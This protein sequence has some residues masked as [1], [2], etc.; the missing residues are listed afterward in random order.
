MIEKTV[1]PKAY[2]RHKDSAANTPEKLELNGIAARLAALHFPLALRV[3]ALLSE[4]L[5][6]S[7]L[8]RCLFDFWPVSGR[9]VTNHDGLLELSRFES[10]CVLQIQK[11]NDSAP[12]TGNSLESYWRKLD[13]M[14]E[15]DKENSKFKKDVD[16]RAALLTVRLTHFEA[17]NVSVIGF[18][19]SHAICDRGSIYMFVS[20]LSHHLDTIRDSGLVQEHPYPGRFM[21]SPG[22]ED[23]KENSITADQLRSSWNTK[24]YGRN[25]LDNPD[26]G[27][28]ESSAS[29]EYSLEVRIEE[30]DIAS[31]K[32]TL[33]A[34]IPENCW[35]SSTECIAATVA[36]A[37]CN[38]TGVGVMNSVDVTT[39][40]NL[41]KCLC[42][43]EAK[44]YFGNFISSPRVQTE[45]PMLD[46][47]MT[48]ETIMQKIVSLALKIHDSCQTCVTSNK[49]TAAQDYLYENMAVKKRL[50]LYDWFLMDIFEN[51]I[52]AINAVAKYDWFALKM[53]SNTNVTAFGGAG[54]MKIPNLVRIL[55]HCK[56]T[57]TIKLGFRSAKEIEAFRTL[58]S[59]IPFKFQVIAEPSNC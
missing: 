7:A 56:Q 14:P 54:P 17:E 21:T 19:F 31:M 11:I 28:K 37:Y 20:S 8:E 57:W 42:Y 47:H 34:L 44:E 33:H 3:E 13:L 35:L 52:I 4:E 16:K 43:S 24:R 1:V 48:D 5:L 32:K 2:G 41:R 51:K 53:G 38:A 30:K 9:L 6:E 29:L 12:P 46:E 55:K 36:L 18:S 22:Y 45:I 26:F 25:P 40:V 15:L 49:E 10:G 23:C 39:I 27:G 58:V 59:A 50:R